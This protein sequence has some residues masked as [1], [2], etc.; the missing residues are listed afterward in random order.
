MKDQLVKLGL[1]GKEAEVYL[2]LLRIG[3]AAASTL[4]RLTGIKRTSIYDVTNRL[5]ELNLIIEFKQGAYAFFVVDDVNKLYLYEKEKADFAKTLVEE[6]KQNKTQSDGIQVTYYKGTEGY[7]EL[8]D[9]ILRANP[10]ELIGWMNLDEFYR[11]IDPQHEE[12]WTKERIRK[13]IQVKL[14]VKKTKLTQN[15]KKQDGISNRETKFLPKGNDFETSCFLYK[16]TTV[17]F[18]PGESATGIRIQQPELYHMQ[19]AIF[20][21][22]WLQC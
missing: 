8:Y 14:I 15:F 11:H 1:S 3:P 20:E 19:K 16:D 2:T 18:C 22:N 12:S 9:D 6:L 5:L 10:K 17:F 21:M 4:A 7:R 13:G